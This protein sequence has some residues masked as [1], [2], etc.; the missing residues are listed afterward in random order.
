MSHMGIVCPHITQV[1]ILTLHTDA[2]TWSMPVSKFL[3]SQWST[4]MVIIQS[5]RGKGIVE[6]Q[7][8]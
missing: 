3:G 6:G 4:K 5:L 8:S 2:V 1:N 7:S